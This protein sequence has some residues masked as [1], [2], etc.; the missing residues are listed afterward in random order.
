MKIVEELQRKVE[1]IQRWASKE[2]SVVPLSTIADNTQESA[3]TTMLHL[4]SSQQRTLAAAIKAPSKGI[5]ARE[6]AKITGRSMNL[7]SASLYKL[8]LQ[9]AL[10]RT[11][12]GREVYYK[13]KRSGIS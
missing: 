2:D 8:Y 11:R 5:T 3:G 4:T 6:T 12:V 7:E 1:Y 10:Q 13:M 9:G